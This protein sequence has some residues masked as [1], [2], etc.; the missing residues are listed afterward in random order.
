MAL[1]IAGPLFGPGSWW[2]S[3]Q[4][5]MTIGGFIKGTSMEDPLSMEVLNIFGKRELHVNHVFFL[6]FRK[7]R[8]SLQ[9]IWSKSWQE[10]RP[11]QWAKI[12]FVSFLHLNILKHCYCP[13]QSNGWSWWMKFGLVPRR[14]FKVCSKSWMM[15]PIWDD[16]RKGWVEAS[17][18]CFSNKKTGRF[19]KSST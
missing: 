18:P 6:R 7:N 1:K 4:I 12:G 13:W 10:K 2:V 8:G 9:T 17:D 16:D 11:F 19:W 15:I 14:C 5:H 3:W